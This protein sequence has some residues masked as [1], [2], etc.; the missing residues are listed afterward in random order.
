VLAEGEVRGTRDVE[1]FVLLA[2][3]GG[4]A[5]TATLKV[6][7]EGGRPPIEHQVTLQP[8]S[9]LTVP[10]AGLGLL[11]GERCSVVVDA[12]GPVAVERS[13]YWSA[14]N[15]YWSAGTNETGQAW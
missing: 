12:T 15:R 1:S 9:R 5:V 8:Q 2:N 14:G 4:A 13:M 11:S 7:R 6:L 3:P 10:L